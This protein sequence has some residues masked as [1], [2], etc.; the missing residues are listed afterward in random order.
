MWCGRHFTHTPF[1]SGSPLSAP[2]QYEK[3]HVP[4]V[5]YIRDILLY[6][7]QLSFLVFPTMRAPE[8]LS[9][10]SSM[11]VENDLSFCWVNLVGGLALFFF[12]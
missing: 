4:I 3:D 11:E 7:M 8:C 9:L 10:L 1:N 2:H 12:F 5:W 6:V